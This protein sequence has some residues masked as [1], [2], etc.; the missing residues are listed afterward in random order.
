MRGTRDG[1][2]ELKKNHEKKQFK[3]SLIDRLKK[4]IGIDYFSIRK[5]KVLTYK[6]IEKLVI[7]YQNHFHVKFS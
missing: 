2:N 5:E 6:Q 4:N 7:L 3:Y 1:K